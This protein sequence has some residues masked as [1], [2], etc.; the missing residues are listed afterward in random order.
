MVVVVGV[1]VAVV[2]VVVWT[3]RPSFVTD[4]VVALVVWEFVVG[5][6]LPPTRFIPS[7]SRSDCN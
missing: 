6:A 2:V 3:F 7:L 5:S 1:V 4:C